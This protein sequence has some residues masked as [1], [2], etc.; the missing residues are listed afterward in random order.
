MPKKKEKIK[1]ENEKVFTMS[2]LEKLAELFWNF[3]LAEKGGYRGYDL[4]DFLY[5]LK[6]LEEIK[7]REG[8]KKYETTDNY[9]ER[10]KNPIT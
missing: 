9:K 10:L 1:T 7:W 8:D 2:Q 5:W 4:D 6:N 3:C